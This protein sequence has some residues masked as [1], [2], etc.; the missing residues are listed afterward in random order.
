M[1]RHVCLVTPGHLSTNPRLVKEA[2]A[3]A[4]AG[5]RVSIVCAEY[6]AWAAAADSQFAQR[7][8][9]VS[10]VRFGRRAGVARHVAQR[11]GQIVAQGLWRATGRLLERA[12]HPVVPALTRAACA[13]RADLYIAHNLAALPAA[14]RAAK[15]HRAIL[16]FDAEDFHRGFWRDDEPDSL[17]AQLTRALE[18]RYLPHCRHLTASS[19]GIS[20]AYEQSCGVRR[21]RVVLNVFPLEAI[22][23]SPPHD[24]P[25]LYWF[26]QTVGP[27][28]GLETAVRAIAIARSRPRL[29]LRGDPSPGYRE[30]L[31]AL[32]RAEQVADRIEWLGPEP[33][34]AMVRLA[35][36]HDMGLAAETSETANHRMCLSNKTFT[37]LMAGIPVLASNTPAQVALQR[38]LDG[39]ML[40]YPQGD[41]AA[42]A[43]CLDRFTGSPE[44][45]AAAKARARQLAQGRFNWETE[46]QAFLD[47][48]ARSLAGDA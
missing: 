8:W 33:P 30:Q 12:F 4:A 46:S 19:E 7:P 44:A 48:V 14:A 28:R 40:V 37:Y 39:A 17:A 16:G 38:E 47:E 31:N 27:G 2:D 20:Q 32:A 15:E 11:I 21:A 10:V 13:V 35:A 18:Q 45:L 42:L 1:T 24:P 34:S 9:A 26:S 3:L 41:A 43:G 36:Q 6:L 23:P 29:V 25:R 5:Y 22:E